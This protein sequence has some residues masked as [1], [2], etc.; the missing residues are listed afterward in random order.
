MWGRGWAD[1][2]LYPGRSGWKR[3]HLPPSGMVK[4]VGGEGASS[5]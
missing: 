1:I 5:R 3:K 4:E 2:Q